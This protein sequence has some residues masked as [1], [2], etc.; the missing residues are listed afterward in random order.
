V[1]FEKF[2][3]SDHFHPIECEEGKCLKGIKR[4]KTPPELN[5]LHF[6]VGQIKFHRIK[7]NSL[8]IIALPFFYDDHN[9]DVRLIFEVL[10]G[11]C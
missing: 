4:V 2:H 5:N 10:V 8:I 11:G 3:L 6:I 1:K 9:V 7:N